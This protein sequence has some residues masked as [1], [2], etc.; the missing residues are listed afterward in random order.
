[1]YDKYHTYTVVLYK[2]ISSNLQIKPSFMTREV[3]NLFTCLFH[4]KE[5][6]SRDLRLQR[7]TKENA[8]W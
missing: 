8:V 6:V 3:P 7:K 1:M 4:K 5:S 2:F